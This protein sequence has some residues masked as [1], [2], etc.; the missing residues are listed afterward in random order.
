M[1]FYMVL[2]LGHWLSSSE[3]ERMRAPYYAGARSLFTV[4]MLEAGTLGTVQALLLMVW[5]SPIVNI[6]TKYKLWYRAIT[7][8]KWTAPILVTT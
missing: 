5:P 8:K 1:T 3:H 2:A 4:Q 7:F 6:A